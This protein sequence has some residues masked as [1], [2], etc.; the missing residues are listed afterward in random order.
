MVGR[1]RQVD[2]SEFKTNSVVSRT[3]RVAIIDPILQK[4]TN[5][6]YSRVHASFLGYNKN[7]TEDTR[8]GGITVHRVD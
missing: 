4:H 8:E 5:K 6:L 1:Q 3:A 7:I 2:L